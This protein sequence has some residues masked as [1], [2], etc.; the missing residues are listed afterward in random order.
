ML[1]FTWCI[2]FLTFPLT[3]T[4]F[5][6][7]FFAA[8]NAMHVLQEWFCSE[9]EAEEQAERERLKK[10]WHREQELIRSNHHHYICVLNSKIATIVILKK[11]LNFR[12]ATSNNVQLLGWYRTQKSNSGNNNCILYIC[13][14]NNSHLSTYHRF[15]KVIQ[16][17]NFLELYN[18]NSHLSFEKFE[19]LQWRTY[20]MWKKI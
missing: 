18:S 17:V 16:L 7:Y 1:L 11:H 6:H 15:E 5:C 3:V 4:C 14:L 9:R 13:F 12:W 8:L 19:L 20:F 2:L 10:Q